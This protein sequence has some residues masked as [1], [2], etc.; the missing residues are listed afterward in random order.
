MT[1]KFDVKY[2]FTKVAQDMY[3]LYDSFNKEGSFKNT[4]ELC[5]F[6]VNTRGGASLNTDTYEMLSGMEIG[7]SLGITSSA[8]EITKTAKVQGIEPWKIA[9]VDGQE[10]FVSASTGCEV[11]DDDEEEKLHKKAS[12]NKVKHTY[13]VAIHTGTLAKT[14]AAHGILENDGYCDDQMYINPGNPD[15]VVVTVE[16]DETPSQVKNQFLNR[17]NKDF[18]GLE[19]DD[20]ECC[21]DYCNCGQQIFD[22]P[23]MKEDEFVLLIPNN[24][25]M[26]GS[27]KDLREY[28]D[29]NNFPTFKVCASNGSTVYDEALRESLNEAKKVEPKNDVHVEAKT[30]FEDESTGEVFTPEQLESDANKANRSLK[31]K[32]LNASIKDLFSKEATVDLDLADKNLLRAALHYFNFEKV[33]YLSDDSFTIKAGD[34]VITVDNDKATM[35]PLALFNDRAL[36]EDSKVKEETKT[37]SILG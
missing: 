19:S 33:A 15:T 17:M 18:L 23:D 12:L 16:S 26:F 11:D 6:L 9:N 8:L 28:V 32:D 20:I 7:D 14:A 5:D 29:A 10:V 30:V 34:A 25:P 3:N 27:E 4:K 37:D 1:K 35:L 36:G 24:R 2:Q 21:H 13:K 31:M 22:F